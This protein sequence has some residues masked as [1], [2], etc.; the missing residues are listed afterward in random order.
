MTTEQKYNMLKALCDEV[1]ET[2]LPALKPNS[3]DAKMHAIIQMSAKF[4]AQYERFMR[5]VQ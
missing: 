2:C 5:A 1:Y 4:R 3:A